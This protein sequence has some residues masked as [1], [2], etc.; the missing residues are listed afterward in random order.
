MSNPIPILIWFRKDFRLADHR[1]LA[2]ESRGRRP[3]IQLVMLDEVAETFGSA[4][5]RRLSQ[6]IEHFEDRLMQAGS[7][8]ILGR[9]N[10]A[11]K[12]QALAREK[13]AED[14]KRTRA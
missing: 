8:L 3:T 6:A 7:R 13:I 5:K 4:H 2:E 10:A 1:A 14:I 11:D 12:L 9:G